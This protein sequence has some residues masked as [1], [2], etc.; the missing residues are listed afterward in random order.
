MLPPA[1]VASARWLHLTKPHTSLPPRRLDVALGRLGAAEPAAQAVLLAVG[2]V[3]HAQGA[4]RLAGAG[5][6]GGHAGRRGLGT[7]MNGRMHG[8]AQ[9]WQLNWLNADAGAAA[10]QG[11]GLTA[12]THV[13]C[14]HLSAVDTALVGHCAGRASLCG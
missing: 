10:A 8:W 12:R 3:L 4:L 14:S 7:C 5:L 1:A 9:Q 6:G 2:R 13:G 11:A